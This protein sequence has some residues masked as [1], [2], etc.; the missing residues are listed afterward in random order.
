M[1][2]DGKPELF[3]EPF[4]GAQ[5]TTLSGDV[6]TNSTGTAISGGGRGDRGSAVE[7][8]VW[9]P[10]AQQVEVILFDNTHQG[11]HDKVIILFPRNIPTLAAP[12]SIILSLALA[13]ALFLLFY[14]IIIIIFFKMGY[15]WY[16]SSL[17]NLVLPALTDSLIS[18]SF[19]H[20]IFALACFPSGNSEGAA[21]KT[22]QRRVDRLHPGGRSW[23]SLQVQD[24]Q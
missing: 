18:F 20:E 19:T 24:R 3:V 10:E 13:L 16:H 15:V 4:F 14:L 21:S 2:T 9:A 6:A 11:E 17:C 5:T 22:G 12:R 8:H 7:F 1:S 23:L